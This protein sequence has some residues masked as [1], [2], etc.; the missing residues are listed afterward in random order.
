VV[1]VGKSGNDTVAGEDGEGSE[2]A[3]GVLDFRAERRATGEEVGEVEGGS[4]ERGE[5]GGD[6]G[7]GDGDA[8]VCCCA[9]GG[10]KDRSLEDFEESGER[11]EFSEEDG[12][13]RGVN[14]RTIP[15]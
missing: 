10:S 6:A 2:W 13:G 1:R 8:T 3:R 15:E 9:R 14:G 7:G 11:E 5:V 4:W 12:G